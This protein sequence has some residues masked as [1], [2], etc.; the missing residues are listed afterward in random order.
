M[1]EEAASQIA[2][3]DIDLHGAEHLA[4]ELEKQYDCVFLPIQASVSN[5]ADVEKCFE[6]VQVKI[7]RL[8]ILVNNAGVCGIIDMDEITMQ[9][10]DRTYDINV[11]GCFQFARAAM[12][13]MKQQRYGRIVNMAS[14]A[15]KIGGLMVGVD[16]STSK[17][18]VLTLTKSL[19]KVGAKYNVTV[20]SIAP[21]LIAT[22]MTGEFGYDPD[23]VPL[24]R[25]GTPEEVADVVL[26]ASSDLSRYMTGACLDVN[27][28]MTM[29]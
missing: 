13:I 18:A 3:V 7:G 14:Q 21:G 29:C 4:Q 26:F 8:D 16:Y 12:R 15:G 17:G 25:I 2:I 24:G 23:M 9:G 22:G 10:W 6:I 27:G 11:K 20:N 5:I 1:A 28:G 19:A